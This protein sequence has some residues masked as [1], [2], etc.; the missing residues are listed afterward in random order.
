[1]R[2]T[3]SLL[4]I[5]LAGYGLGGCGS[6]GGS[7]SA[8]S[9]PNDAGSPSDVASGVD[10]GVT[11]GV[12]HA[13]IG[14]IPVAPGVEKT[15][16]ITKR[17]G[18]A[19]D[20]V[21]SG[22]SATLAPG[23]HHLIVY[24]STATQEDLTPTPCRPFVGLATQNVVP[25]VL[26]N[27]LAIDWTFPSGIGVE[28]PANQMLRIEAHYINTTSATLQ[29]AGSVTFQ[30]SPKSS[31][32]PYTPASFLFWG[33]DNINIPPMS[34][35]STGPIFMAG[36][37]NTHL[38]SIFTHQHELGTGI[39]VWASSGPGDM[40]NSI[41]NDPDWSNPSWRLVNPPVDFNGTNG[42]TFQ[43]SWDN[44]TPYPIVFGESAL[45]EMCFIG[46]YYYPGN[47]FQFRLASAVTG[48]FSDAGS[49]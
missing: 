44:T 49:D 41:A 46:G 27:K 28:V 25:L 17:L 48:G 10:V 26:V 42:L 31:A 22:Y 18:D 6:A 13:N 7:P 9:G 20:L 19:D 16:C 43:C 34:K 47:G 24:A 37:A 29:G 36:T 3:S 30:G 33:T 11:P 4:A 38:I 21:I 5:A 8:P 39:Q 40:S 35:S 2:P 23:S 32:P 12:A 1:M 45:D 14:P 15:V